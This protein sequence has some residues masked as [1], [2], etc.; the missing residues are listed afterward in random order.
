MVFDPTELDI[1]E[2]Q[3]PREDW[4]ATLYGACTE[5]IPSNTP[6]PLGTGFTMRIFVD[7]NHVGDMVTCYSR[8]F[9]IFL[10][11]VP[12]YWYSKKQGS[13]ETSSFGSEFI[14]MNSCCEY[15]YGLHYKLRMMG[16]PVKLSTFV[17]RDNQSVLVNSSKPHST[18][19]EKSASIAFLFVIEGDTKDEWRVTYLNM[20]LNYS[21]IA[22]KSLPGGQK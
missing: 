15:I 17:F 14:A 2:S 18:L 5:D 21:D 12:I 11:N 20:N 13:Y 9:I 16:I 4:T 6:E 22:T 7:S 1:N 8:T 19:K 10:N 3:F